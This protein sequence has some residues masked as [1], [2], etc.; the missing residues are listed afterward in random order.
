M[1]L[2]ASARHRWGVEDGGQVGV[3]DLDG[4]LLLVPGGI[5]AA[6]RALRDAVSG[7]RYERAVAAIDDRDLSN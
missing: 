4:A 2:P 7:G 5:E 1:S 3:I 6:R